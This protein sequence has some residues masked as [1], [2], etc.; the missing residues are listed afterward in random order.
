MPTILLEGYTAEEVLALPREQLDALVFREDALVFSAG[1]AQMLGRFRIED[2]TLVLELGHV[3]GGGEG[4]L[5]AL[6]ALASRYARREGLH[7]IEWRV[8]AV[9]CARPNPKLGRVLQRRGFVVRDIPDVGECFWL[10]KAVDGSPPP[11]GPTAMI[12]P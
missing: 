5:P 3:D 6:A 10:R 4:G 8:H 1:S 2:R 12:A 7:W 11:D 9:H